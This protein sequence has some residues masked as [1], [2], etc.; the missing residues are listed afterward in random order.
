LRNRACELG[1]PALQRASLRGRR[2]DNWAIQL[3]FDMESHGPVENQSA[4]LLFRARL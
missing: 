2:A 4:G 1:S 3:V